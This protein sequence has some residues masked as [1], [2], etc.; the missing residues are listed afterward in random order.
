MGEE[1]EHIM[2]EMKQ[3]NIPRNAYDYMDLLEAYSIAGNPRKMLQVLQT[4][5]S[6]GV[7]VDIYHISSAMAAC[8]KWNKDLLPE[9]LDF[10]ELY[11]LKH[12]I[13]TYTTMLRYCKDTENSEVSRKIMKKVFFIFLFFWYSFSNFFF[14]SCTDERGKCWTKYCDN[15][16]IAGRDANSFGGRIGS[17][18]SKMQ[19]PE[20]KIQHGSIQHCVFPV[21]KERRLGTNERDV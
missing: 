6:N 7:A 20:H 21:G 11:N 1:I 13:Y 16:S 19:R 18:A 4:M 9:V 15:G 2:Q 14:F 8:V 10:M 12:D 17:V 5:E 3:Q